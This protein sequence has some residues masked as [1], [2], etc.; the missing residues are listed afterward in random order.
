MNNAKAIT[1]IKPS[2]PAAVKETHEPKES[3][4]VKPKP[5]PKEKVKPVPKPKP[6]KETKP[7]PPKKEP[8]PKAPKKKTKA[9]IAAEQEPEIRL[10]DIVKEEEKKEPNEEIDVEGEDSE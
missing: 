4:E 8:K 10:D 9:D 5:S 1:P 2:K 3:K 7:K 6:V